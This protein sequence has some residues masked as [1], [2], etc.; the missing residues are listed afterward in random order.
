LVQAFCGTQSVVLPLVAF[1]QRM[2]LAGLNFTAGSLA[3]LRAFASYAAL[4][5]VE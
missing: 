5:L 3:V 1:Q 2:E 4:R